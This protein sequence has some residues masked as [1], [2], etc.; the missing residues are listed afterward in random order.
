[1][2]NR[3]G[4][5]VHLGRDLHRDLRIWCAQQ[6]PRVTLQAALDAAVRLWLARPADEGSQPPPE[7]VDRPAGSR[8]KDSA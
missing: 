8:R 5:T 3:Q 4:P 7:G 6:Q 1:M 2:A